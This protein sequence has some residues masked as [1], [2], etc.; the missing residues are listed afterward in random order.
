MIFAEITSSRMA[1]LVGLVVHFVYWCVFG[2]FNQIPIDNYHKTL[3]FLTVQKI[4]NEVI[5][6][7]NVNRQ[8]ATF[9]MP[10]VVLAIRREVDSVFH[11][12]YPLLF[13]DPVAGDA[14]QNNI[15]LLLTKLLDPN[16]LFSRFSSLES[17]DAAI[18]LKLKQYF[19]SKTTKVRDLFYTNS[20]L[21]SA[22]L[23][24]KAEG[25]VRARFG[26]TQ[27]LSS[28]KRVRSRGEQVDELPPIFPGKKKEPKSRTDLLR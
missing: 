26:G 7:Y 23:P 17:G 28:S 25:K 15:S 6:Q 16:V 22:L 11:T 21:V 20:A 5:S 27:K 14:A 19:S 8:F 10:M 9:F 18:S 3:L 1:R 12:K 24:H 2:H 13:K 4:L